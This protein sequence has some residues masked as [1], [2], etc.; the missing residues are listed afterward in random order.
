MGSLNCGRSEIKCAGRVL[1]VSPG[2]E[3]ADK[4]RIVKS[5]DKKRWETNNF[6]M[7]IPSY[8]TSPERVGVVLIHWHG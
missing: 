6:F 7:N 2:S 5:S 8:K 3:I 4:A 1:E